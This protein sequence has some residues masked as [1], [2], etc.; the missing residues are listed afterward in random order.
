MPGLRPVIVLARLEAPAAK[1]PYLL[2]VATPVHMIPGV[3]IERGQAL[4]SV[5][6]GVQLAH[7]YRPLRSFCFKGSPAH[8]SALAG[9]AS[10]RI[11]PVIREP[12]GRSSRSCSS[13]FPAAFRPPAFAFWAP[14]PARG[15]RPPYG[16]PTAPPAH[17][18]ACAADPGG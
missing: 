5:H 10:A 8:V 12:S 13:R 7:Q 2:L 9:R 11:R 18:R 15:F 6:R 3:T 14:C 16:R 4:R 1:P 17:T